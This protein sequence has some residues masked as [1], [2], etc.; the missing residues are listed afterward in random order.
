[1]FKNEGNLFC[2]LYIENVVFWQK[3]LNW[4][5]EQTT[6]ISVQ[7]FIVNWLFIVIN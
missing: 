1:M 3:N 6:T 4:Y 7:N 5:D 2:S